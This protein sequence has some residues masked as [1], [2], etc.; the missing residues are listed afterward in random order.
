MPPV[1]SNA[2][3]AYE[4]EQALVSNAVNEVKSL[5]FGVFCC[6][7][8]ACLSWIPYCCYYQG[9]T[10]AVVDKLAAVELA[11][12]DRKRAADK[13]ALAAAPPVVLT[14]PAPI[15]PAAADEPTTSPVKSTEPI[16]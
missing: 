4:D 15:Q 11:K 1:P 2:P 7:C 5:Y 3:N 12:E 16:A 9:S 13:A 10:V 14:A 8:T 6:L